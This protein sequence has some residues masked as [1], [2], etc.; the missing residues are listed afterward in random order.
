MPLNH[1][2]ATW[3][4]D[5]VQGIERSRDDD[6]ERSRDED[7]DFGDI[8]DSG[9]TLFER[10]LNSGLPDAETYVVRR[11]SECFVMLNRFP[12]TT[13]HS[14][15]LPNRAVADLEDLTAAEQDQL[16]RLVRDAV[17][18]LK[19]GMHCDGVNVGINL[20]IVAG[21]SQVDHLHVHVVPRWQ[22]DANFMTVAGET[23]VLPVSLDEAWNTIRSAWPRD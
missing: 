17:V 7:T 9:Q 18:A 20:G 14:M 2:W 11:D 3:R 4:S 16:W 10:I 15:V 12:Y 13:G 1:L 23:R 6:I 19:A 5:Y 8:A 22:G 21:G